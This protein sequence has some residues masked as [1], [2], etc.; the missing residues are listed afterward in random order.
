MHGLQRHAEP[1]VEDS[2]NASL[3]QDMHRIDLI[4]VTVC[5]KALMWAA[6]ILNGIQLRCLSAAL[7]LPRYAQGN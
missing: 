7:A 6:S 1:H 2:M 3:Q 4:W 5:C